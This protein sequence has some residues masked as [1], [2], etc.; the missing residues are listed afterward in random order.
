MIVNYSYDNAALLASEIDR[1][2]MSLRD[3]VPSAPAKAKK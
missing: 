3:C 1:I 2:I